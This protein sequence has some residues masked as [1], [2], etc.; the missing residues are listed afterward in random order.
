MRVLLY[1]WG[2]CLY[3]MGVL[4]PPWGPVFLVMINHAGTPDWEPLSHFINPFRPGC[5]LPRLSELE[6]CC[7]PSLVALTP[8][9]LQ[10]AVAT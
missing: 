1:A 4:S 6:R 2:V 7:M 5:G 3:F 9:L 8:D 10:G